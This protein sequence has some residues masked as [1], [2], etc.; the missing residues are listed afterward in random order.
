[1]TWFDIVKS[2]SKK[3]ILEG[4][5]VLKQNI[6]PDMLEPRGGHKISYSGNVEREYVLTLDKNFDNFYF[7]NMYFIIQDTDLSRSEIKDRVVSFIK[8]L[9]SGDLK[10]DRY[11]TEK[12]TST[13]KD[14]IVFMKGIGKDRSM[15]TIAMEKM[16]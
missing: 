8:G 4:L 14:R 9:N 2:D 5:S 7:G 16:E 3:E 13:S 15:L 1:M 6:K 12:W 11:T 10:I